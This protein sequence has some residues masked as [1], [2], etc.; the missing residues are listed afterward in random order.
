M[1][2]NIKQPIP[3]CLHAGVS[4]PDG[5]SD[6]H[7]LQEALNGRLQKFPVYELILNSNIHK[8]ISQKSGYFSTTFSSKSMCIVILCIFICDGT[9]N[10][11]NKSF[12]RI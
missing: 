1:D 2:V 11:N 5:T 8:F 3:V 6:Y 10:P 7:S 12:T 9:L 4:S